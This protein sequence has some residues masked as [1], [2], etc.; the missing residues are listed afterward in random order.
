MVV[1]AGINVLIVNLYLPASV[2]L[3]QLTI[4][5]DEQSPCFLYMLGAQK[6]LELLTNF[7]TPAA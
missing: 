7:Y 6:N 2:T 1:I 4:S 5:V 3:Q